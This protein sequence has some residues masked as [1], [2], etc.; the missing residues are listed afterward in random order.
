MFLLFELFKEGKYNLIIEEQF[1]NIFVIEI[2]LVE[3]Y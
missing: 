3:I 1:L 2:I